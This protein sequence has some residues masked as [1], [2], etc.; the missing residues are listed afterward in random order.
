MKKGSYVG[1]QYVWEAGETLEKTAR[2]N[3]SE[4]MKTGWWAEPLNWPVL[5]QGL[6]SKKPLPA[7][8]A[9]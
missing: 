7:H 8:K 6:T 1:K 9:A 3:R 5:A 2:L 4:T